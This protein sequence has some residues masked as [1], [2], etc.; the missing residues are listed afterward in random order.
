MQ[1]T[2]GFTLIEFILVMTLFVLTAAFMYP[3]GIGFY[4]AQQ[5]DSFTQEV[6][7]ALQSAHTAAITQKHDSAHGVRFLPT[8]YVQFEGAGY[9]TRNTD[10][11]YVR[12][13]PYGI[14]RTGIDEVVFSAYSG[15]A[16]VS[17][18]VLLSLSQATNTIT[19][20]TAGLVY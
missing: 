5:L 19:V 7:R 20:T 18:E 15:G 16:S 17:G 1:Y 4:H 8:T 10:Q 14:T 2:K 3:V 12:P 6:A 11:D 9:D 13:I